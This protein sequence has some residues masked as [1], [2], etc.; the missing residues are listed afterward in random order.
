MASISDR[1]DARGLYHEV[2]ILR[3]EIAKTR[4][5]LLSRAAYLHREALACE[6]SG[7]DAG[8]RERCAARD[9][10]RMAASEISITLA[11]VTRRMKK[12]DNDA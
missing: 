12:I 8:A 10:Y 3:N 7:Y 11:R 9:A 4:Y 1:N 2:M 5:G 6:E